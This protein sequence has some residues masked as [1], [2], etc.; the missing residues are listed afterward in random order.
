MKVEVEVFVLFLMASV[1]F[2]ALFLSFRFLPFV[3]TSLPLLCVLTKAQRHQKSLP[4]AASTRGCAFEGPGPIKIR[5]GTAMGAV[6]S[7]VVDARGAVAGVV[8]PLLAPSVVMVGGVVE[9]ALDKNSTREKEKNR[10]REQGKEKEG[11]KEFFVF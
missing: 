2:D 9:I 5:L 3:T 6:A 1:F 11:E 7:V 8:S 4:C 10:E